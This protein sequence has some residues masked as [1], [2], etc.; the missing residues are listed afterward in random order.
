MFSGDF[1]AVF[2]KTAHVFQLEFL[3]P[4]RCVHKDQLWA[5]SCLQ[6]MSNT[7][8]SPNGCNVHLGQMMTFWITLLIW[9]NLSLSSYK[10]VYNTF[11]YAVINLK[12]F[13]RASEFKCLGIGLIL[14]S[15]ILLEFL[16]PT[17]SSHASVQQVYYE[18]DKLAFR[19]CEHIE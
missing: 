7:V 12:L 1:K 13:S 3:S 15:Q 6:F 4:S 16:L 14:Y 19:F 18:L 10:Y 5:L 9:Y 11:Q 2:V 8:Y 17:T